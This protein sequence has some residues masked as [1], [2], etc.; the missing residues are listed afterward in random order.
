MKKLLSIKAISVACGILPHTIRVWEKRYN[1]F[2]PE[3]TDG[4]Q[5]L[6]SEEDLARAKLMATLIAQGHSIS[7]LAKLDQD[8][9]RSLLLASNQAEAAPETIEAAVGTRKLLQYLAN[10]N[11]DMVASEMQFL[12]MSTG[13]KEFIFKIVLPVMQ[14]IGMMVAKGKYSVTQEHIVSTIIRDQLSKINLPN[15]SQDFGR[16]ALATPD[17][18]LHELAILIADIICRANR[19][20]TS[21][22][23][24]SHPAN[25]LGEAVSALK[26][27]TVIMGVVS[28]DQWDYEKNMIPYLQALDKHLTSKVRV[29]LGGGWEIDFPKFKNIEQV[30]VVKSFEDFDKILLG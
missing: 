28:S 26:C 23:G 7:N 20:S 14:E 12:R 29:I 21:Y 16:F 4:G 19:V 25:C 13:A 18:N 2:S 22:L 8:N 24:A 11:I 30:V 5:R 27:Q 3:R 6:Y 1:A 15:T 9:L 10:Y 17:G